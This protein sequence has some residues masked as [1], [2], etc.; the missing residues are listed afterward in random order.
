VFPAAINVHFM[1]QLKNKILDIL[2]K[3]IRFCLLLREEGFI[4]LSLVRDWF[5][6]I[7]FNM[8]LV[9]TRFDGVSEAVAA[10]PGRRAPGKTLGKTP[11]ANNNFALAA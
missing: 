6:R 9:S 7:S 5:Y 4:F 3:M 11:T 2:R 1:P 8:S 10:C